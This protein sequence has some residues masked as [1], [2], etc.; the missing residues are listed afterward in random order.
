M[1]F[2]LC[3]YHNV[4]FFI[5]LLKLRLRHNDVRHWLL[6]IVLNLHA[7]LYKGSE[8]EDAETCYLIVLTTKGGPFKLDMACDFRRYKTWATTINR[9]LKIYTYEKYELQCYWNWCYHHLPFVSICIFVPYVFV[10]TIKYH[11]YN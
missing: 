4:H 3:F 7:E 1:C 8:G 5:S 11:P 9:M 6:G 2:F 10:T